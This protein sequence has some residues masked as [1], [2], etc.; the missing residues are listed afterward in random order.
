MLD[1]DNCHAL[2]VITSMAPVFQRRFV[3][4][5]IGL[6]GTDYSAELSNSLAVGRVVCLPNPGDRL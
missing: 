6:A 4:A 1:A 5:R 3:V 2:C